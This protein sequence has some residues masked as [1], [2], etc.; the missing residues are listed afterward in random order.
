M[1]PFHVPKDGL[2]LKCHKLALLN[3]IDHKLKYS[4]KVFAEMQF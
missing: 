3:G 2:H 4:K 1:W